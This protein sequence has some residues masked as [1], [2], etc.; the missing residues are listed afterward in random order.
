MTRWIDHPNEDLL[1][2][3]AEHG[4]ADPALAEPLARLGAAAVLGGVSATL[5]GIVGDPR[6]P[7]IARLRALARIVGALETSP[8]PTDEQPVAV[9]L[10]VPTEAPAARERAAIA[11]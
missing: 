2:R 4:L 3:A 8:S 7:E 1:H 9:A 10:A 5:L 11:C 6:Q